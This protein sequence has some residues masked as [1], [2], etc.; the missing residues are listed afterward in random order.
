MLYICYSFQSF[1]LIE[2]SFLVTSAANSVIM[3]YRINSQIWLSFSPFFSLSL[4]FS[5][6]TFLFLFIQIQFVPRWSYIQQ[7]QIDE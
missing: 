1:D 6:N 4:K 7:L 3:S 2:I 5:V